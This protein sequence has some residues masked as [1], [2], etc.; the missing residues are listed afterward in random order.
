MFIIF[1]REG[2]TRSVLDLRDHGPQIHSSLI[3]PISRM[4]SISPYSLVVVLYCILCRN[5]SRCWFVEAF[6]RFL[7]SFPTTALQHPPPLLLY[8]YFIIPVNCYFSEDT[9]LCL[10]SLMDREL[11]TGEKDGLLQLPSDKTLLTDPVFRPLVEKY[12]AVCIFF[13]ASC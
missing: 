4:S 3:T 13:I 6:I 2:A 12:A 8:L 11:L 7:F 10:F 1:P 9:P 5:L